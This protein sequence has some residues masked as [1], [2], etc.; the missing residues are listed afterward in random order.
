MIQISF[1][2]KAVQNQIP[3]CYVFVAYIQST[4]VISKSKGL[5]KYF[6]ISVLQRIRFAELREKIN[7]TTTF[8]K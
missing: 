8:Q 4:L 5:L 3:L 6:E 1:Q 7:Q 2:I